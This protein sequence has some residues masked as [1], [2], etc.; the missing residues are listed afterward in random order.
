[1]RRK[2][3]AAATA[4]ALGITMTTTGAMAFGG[5]GG[6]CLPRRRGGCPAPCFSVLTAIWSTR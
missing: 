2:L 4:I 3:I 5:G 6:Q 1:M